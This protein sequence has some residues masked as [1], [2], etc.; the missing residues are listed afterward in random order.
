[1]SLAGNSGRAI[2]ARAA[3]HRMDESGFTLFEI[4]IVMVIAAMAMT[5]VSVLYRKPSAATLVK[6]AAM[7]TAS[8]LRDLRAYAMTSGK[9]RV[10]EIE[11]AARLLRFGEARAPM[12]LDPSI[13]I[14]VTAADGER[15]SQTSAGIRFFPNGSSTGATI[16]LTSGQ[17][18]YE[19]RVNWLT[20]RVS[21]VAL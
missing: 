7:L 11:P 3:A 5:S 21:A 4:L 17:Q 15:R 13:D 12:R 2:S 14:A 16:K 19:V 9:E 6:A 18:S 20:G 1:M 10:A 8:G